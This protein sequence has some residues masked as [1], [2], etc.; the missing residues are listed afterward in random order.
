MAARVSKCADFATRQWI[1]AQQAAATTTDALKL[2]GLSEPAGV[3]GE[4]AY[5]METP[6]SYLAHVE[7]GLGTDADVAAQSD[8][9]WHD[10]FLTYWTL[11]EAYLKARGLGVGKRLLAWLAH[12][13]LERGCAR[14]D[15]AV[16][17]W[18]KP[19]IGFYLSLGAVAQDEWTTFR[20]TGAA[21]G[22]LAGRR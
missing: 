12:T 9:T 15:W 6:G 18:N 20:L 10:R 4:S 2:H 22:R 5:L 1:R 17:D 19:S 13:T 8:D 16:L 21:L 14:L 11:K 7:E 3:R